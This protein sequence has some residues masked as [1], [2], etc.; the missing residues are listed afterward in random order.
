MR[1]ESVDNQS[2]DLFLAQWMYLVRNGRN[3][4]STAD[5]DI[6][7]LEDVFRSLSLLKERFK[8]LDHK[9]LAKVERFLVEQVTKILFHTSSPIAYSLDSFYNTVKCHYKN[10]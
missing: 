5:D 6:T 7:P 4:L 10:L 3:L 8:S 1:A 9:K 2:D